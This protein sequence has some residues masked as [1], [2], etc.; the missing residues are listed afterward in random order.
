M[1]REI[2]IPAI[3]LLAVAAVAGWTRKP[4]APQPALQP[5]MPAEVYIQTDSRTALSYLIRP[6]TDQMA[7][8]FKER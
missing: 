4:A 7:R 2:A 5:G 6:L 3:V 8:A 1:R